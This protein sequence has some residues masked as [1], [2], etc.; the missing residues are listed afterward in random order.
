MKPTRQLHRTPPGKENDRHVATPGKAQTPACRALDLEQSQQDLEQVQQDLREQF[1][2]QQQQ[3]SQLGLTSDLPTT[4][5]ALDIELAQARQEHVQLEATV[6]TMQSTLDKLGSAVIQDGPT[7]QQQVA[8]L[9]TRLDDMGTLLQ[10]FMQRLTRVE[11]QQAPPAAATATGP[12]WLVV[13]TSQGTSPDAV[14]QAVS[15]AAGCNTS[16]VLAVLPLSKRTQQGPSTAT[17]GAGAAAAGAAATTGRATAATSGA[18]AAASSSYAAAAAGP[19]NAVAGPAPS[20]RCS[21][22]VK[23][24]A[25]QVRERALQGKHRLR[26]L[27]AHR[28]TYLEPKRTPEQQRA[29]KQLYGQAQRLKQQGTGYR[30]TRDSTG[31]E[32]GLQRQRRDGS[33]EDTPAAPAPPPSATPAAAAATTKAPATAAAGAT[34]ATP[35]HRG[36]SQSQER[37]KQSPSGPAAQQQQ[38]DEQQQQQDEQQQQQQDAQQQQQTGAETRN[39]KKKKK[40]KQQAGAGSGST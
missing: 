26:H 8:A 37:R 19:S 10:Q 30:W 5:K 23:V 4:V 2:S 39:S 3:L 38:Q 18:A 31:V 29:Y 20:G 28:R 25:P 22:L 35:A 15:H 32:T 21:Y 6:T 24:A 16:A 34:G 11:S 36:R 33:W 1:G 7:V 9:R 12:A 14:Q 27:A 13:H 17:A 40:G